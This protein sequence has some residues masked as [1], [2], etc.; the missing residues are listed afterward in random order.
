MDDEY[1]VCLRKRKFKKQE[2]ADDWLDKGIETNHYTSDYHVYN[3]PY[4]FSFH[5]GRK[6]KQKRNLTNDNQQV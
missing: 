3:C 2:W 5:I 1:F 6:P 4:C